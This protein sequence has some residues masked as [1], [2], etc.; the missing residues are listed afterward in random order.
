MALLIALPLVYGED[1]SILPQVP[2]RDLEELEGHGMRHGTGPRD[3]TASTVTGLLWRVART[4]HTL[5]RVS[6]QSFR[7]SW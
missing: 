7:T 3:P 6:A 2:K 5:C 1:S 4:T